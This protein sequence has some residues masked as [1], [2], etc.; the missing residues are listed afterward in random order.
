M[1][2]LEK[3]TFDDIDIKS[4]GEQIKKVIIHKFGDI[5][6]FAKEIGMEAETVNRHLE[7]SKLD[8]KLFK[9]K[10][11]DAFST[12]LDELVKSQEDQIKEM[13]EHI[14]NNIEIY[15]DHYD[16]HTFR[17]LQRLCG[18]NGFELEALKMSRNIGMYYFYNAT[19]DRAIRAMQ[20]AVSS[21]KISSYLIKWKSELGLMYFSQCDYKRSRKNRE[22]VE[23]LLGEIDEIN[24]IDERTIYLHYYRYGLLENSTDNYFSA[25]KRFQKSLKYAKISSD[26]GDTMMNIGLSFELRENYQ[27]AI[28]YYNKALDVFDDD[29]SKSRVFNNLAELYKKLGEYDKALNYIQR[30]FNYIGKNNI[31]E[32]FIF[33]ETYSQIQML[34]GEY[35]EVIDK[36]YTLITDMEDIILYK[37]IVIEGIKTLISY[38]KR[39]DNI[40]MLEHIED[41]VTKLIRKTPEHYEKY[42]NNLYAIIGEI[43]LYILRKEKS[44]GEV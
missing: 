18:E 40:S 21:I 31:S 16:I 8:S 15:K 2:K 3:L 10:L 26:I 29:L 11:C 44:I 37:Q 4:P 13:V 42:L 32:Y 34:K 38:C 9:S 23:K 28:E 17:K 25:E 6:S 41:F 39:T 33:Y 19:I 24:E 27:E 20:E 7:K 30:A 5:D 35:Q 12:S 1:I 43:R 36:L 22:D 14:Y